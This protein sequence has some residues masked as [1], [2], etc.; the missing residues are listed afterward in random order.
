M[1][2]ACG[3]VVY[4]LPM[5]IIS[6]M[7]MRRLSVCQRVQGPLTFQDVTLKSWERARLGTRARYVPYIHILHRVLQI[8]CHRLVAWLSI[9]VIAI[10]M[11]R[12]GKDFSTRPARINFWLILLY[13]RESDQEKLDC[14]ESVHTF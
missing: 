10:T 9:V 11:V 13:S 12:P 5:F 1:H 14:P 2:D 7:F 3:T 8:T 6:D 4:D